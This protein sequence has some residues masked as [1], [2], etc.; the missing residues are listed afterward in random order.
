MARTRIDN[1]GR[2][3]RAGIFFVALL[4]LLW[5]GG[6]EAATKCTPQNFC[7][8]ESLTFTTPSPGVVAAS[9]LS[10]DASVAN[11]ST[12]LDRAHWMEAMVLEFPTTGP[13][14][15]SFLTRS[16]LLPDKLIIAGGGACEP[17]TYNTCGGGHGTI[18]AHVVPIFGPP[19]ETTGAFGVEIVR[20]VQNVDPGIWATYD[21]LIRPCIVMGAGNCQPIGTEHWKLVIPEE[22]ASKLVLPGEMNREVIGNT[23]E[24]TLAS[25][26]LSLDGESNRVDG[27]PAPLPQS[28]TK[29]AAS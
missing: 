9:P 26:K 25:I 28:Y 8:T 10:F 21:M 2:T 3:V 5:T 16:A 18:A 29:K 24:G 13:G 1:R 19:F 11:T 6:A 22:N 14:T 17:P 15:P 23:I 12:P 27:Q 20:N 4:S 7:I